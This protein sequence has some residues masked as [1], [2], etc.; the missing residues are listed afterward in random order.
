MKRVFIW[1]VTLILFADRLNNML[2]ITD[3]SGNEKALLHETG[4]ANGICK[5]RN[6]AL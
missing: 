3:F 5:L 4:D 2:E 6:F 1:T